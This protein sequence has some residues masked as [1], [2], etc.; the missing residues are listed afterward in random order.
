MKKFYF[1]MIA[2]IPGLLF[3]DILSAQVLRRPM[4]TAYTGTGAYSR[5]HPDA[6]S[7]IANQAIL[8]DM[9]NISAGVYGERRF[10][11]G[12][13]SNYLGVFILPALSGSFGLK[14]NY[15]G[16]NVYHESTFGMAYGKKLGN[17]INTGI[18]FNYHHIRI[19]GYS[20]ASAFSFEAA[21]L[22]HISD[23]FHAGMQVSNPVGGN[24][25]KAG[26]EKLPSI[27]SFGL[28]Y[29]ASG[30]FLASAVIEK[31]EDQ[32][33]N[34]NAG[35]Q[36]KPAPLFMFHTGISTATASLWV[37]AGFF[38]HAVKLELIVSDHPVLGITPGLSLSFNPGSVRR[39]N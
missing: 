12:E 19:A 35:I 25:F 32:P 39:S 27:Y 13:L 31:E 37:G 30:K 17:T 26:K 3:T 9:K 20:N 34:V 23:K 28:G 38:L 16:F 24:F 29:E 18:Q 21:T 5:N 36:Y 4:V 2:W 10:L 15:S 1:T 22:I 7:F 8:A 6:F 14:I 11:L 33:V